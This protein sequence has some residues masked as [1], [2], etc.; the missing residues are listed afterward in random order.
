VGVGVGFRRGGGGGS[1]SVGAIRSVAGRVVCGVGLGLGAA[2]GDGEAAGLAGC[3]LRGR[4]CPR[5]AI[6]RDE[7]IKTKTA[8]TPINLRFFSRANVEHLMTRLQD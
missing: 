4:S 2:T 1:P 8:S 3:V 7:T 6:P 5:P